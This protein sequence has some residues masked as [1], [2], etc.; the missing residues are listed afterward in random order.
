VLDL[1][2]LILMKLMAS[3]GVDIGDMTRM[4]GLAIKE[5]LERAREVVRTYSP[6]DS[7]DLET[8]IVLGKREMEP[9]DG[10]QF[11]SK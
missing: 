5:D 11:F 4:L 7:E 1:P 3:R 9:P 6:E 8:L 2:Y 10:E